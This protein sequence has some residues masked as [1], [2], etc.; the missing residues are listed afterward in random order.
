MSDAYLVIHVRVSYYE[1]YRLCAVHSGAPSPE[2][3]ADMLQDYLE[4]LGLRPRAPGAVVEAWDDPD[5]CM[6]HYR[7]RL[8]R[9]CE[10][11]AP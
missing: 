5:V 8:P 11:P 6:R 7:Q 4:T 2:A 1:M 10:E 3:G 9:V